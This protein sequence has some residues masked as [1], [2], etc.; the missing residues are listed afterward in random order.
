MLGYREIE[1]KVKQIHKIVEK[2]VKQ[3]LYKKNK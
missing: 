3:N 2:V 1:L